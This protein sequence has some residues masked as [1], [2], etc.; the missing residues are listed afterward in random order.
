MP[1]DLCHWRTLS[2]TSI[3]ES[4]PVTDVVT[5]L[6]L[7]LLR[8]P[9]PP[10]SAGLVSAAASGGMLR[11][12]TPAPLR[13]RRSPRTALSKQAARILLLIVRSHFHRCRLHR[14]VHSH[15]IVGGRGRCRVPYL[16]CWEPWSPPPPP[17]PPS[18][19]PC[20]FRRLAGSL[21]CSTEVA[22]WRFSVVECLRFQRWG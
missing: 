18:P 2:S 5:Y 21:L 8:L 9:P 19:R 1:N 3:I 13:A 6:P 16:V 15:R 7:P 10:A 20:C 22:R 4:A 14:I 11:P 17:C 12:A